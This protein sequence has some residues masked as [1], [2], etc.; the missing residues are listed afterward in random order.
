MLVKRLNLTVLSRSVDV[1]L[2]NIKWIKI[3]N[4]FLKNQQQQEAI[5]FDSSTSS[6]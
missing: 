3:V 6:R 1:Y 2:N 4:N 5:G